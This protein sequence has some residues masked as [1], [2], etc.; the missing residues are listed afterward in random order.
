MDVSAHLCY[1][2]DWDLWRFR[3]TTKTSVGLLRKVLV[4]LWDIASHHQITPPWV[5]LA[6]V[7]GLHTCLNQWG[8]F[9][10]FRFR[11]RACVLAEGIAG[12]HQ[13][14]VIVFAILIVTEA[15]LGDGQCCRLNGVF[16]H[17]LP[18]TPYTTIPWFCVV[19]RLAPL[20]LHLILLLPPLLVPL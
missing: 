18:L 14:C 5:L 3:S 7:A 1:Q 15:R 11:I 20:Q 12:R 9:L 10:F 13:W 2:C 16:F 17:P 8:S 4:P 19:L 6:R